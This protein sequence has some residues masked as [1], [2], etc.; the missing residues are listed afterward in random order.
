M[1]LYRK[2]SPQELIFYNYE[3]L[4]PI[5]KRQYLFGLTKFFQLH[6]ASGLVFS[7]RN[8]P[9]LGEMNGYNRK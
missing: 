1:I 9:N 5:P 8:I 7:I 6:I 2:T 4:E 3:Y